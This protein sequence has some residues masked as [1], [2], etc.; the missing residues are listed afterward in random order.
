MRVRWPHTRSCSPR[1]LPVVSAPVGLATLSV[2]HNA[3]R[4]TLLVYVMIG[5][6]VVV[7]LAVLGWV[8]RRRRQRGIP[9]PARMPA[10]IGTL[11]AEFDGFYV[12]TTL[13][14]QPL[15]RVAVRGLGFRARATIAV[16][17]LG[18]VLSLP[19]NTV[20]IPRDT[21]REVTRS[22]YAIDRVVEPGG[23][24]LLAWTLGDTPLD[25]YFRVEQ[26][27]ELVRA[28]ESLLARST[29]KKA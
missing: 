1:G 25:S 15:N 9:A 5:F 19:G 10:D 18:V 22:N 21:V 4:T 20:F 23:L 3:T 7:A 14:G 13:E 11:H 2:D 12:A 26:T 28:L 29:G 27:E 6:T 16:A 8:R 24:V 17:E